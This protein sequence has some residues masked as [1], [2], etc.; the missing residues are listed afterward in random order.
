VVAYIC[1]D[2][3][4]ATDR[5]G[6]NVFVCHLDVIGLP[7]S[8][9]RNCYITHDKFEADCKSAGGA[10]S[11]CAWNPEDSNSPSLVYH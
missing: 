3:C 8:N 6:E 4:C 7:N 9:R 2:L 5:E 11:D 1:A 10:E